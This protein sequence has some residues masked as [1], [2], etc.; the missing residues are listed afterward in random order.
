VTRNQKYDA[1]TRKIIRQTL[2]T[3]SCCVDIGCHKGEILDLMLQSSSKGLKYGFEPIP[4]LFNSLREKYK[5]DPT[6][7]INPTALYNTTGK[8][9]FQ[10][11]INAPAYSGIKK[12]KYDGKNVEIEQITVN[13]GLMDDIIPADI[14][15]DLMKIDVEGAEFQVMKGALAILKRCKPVVIFEFGLGAADF[16]GSTPELLY[17]FITNDCGMRIS[18]LKGYLCNQPSLTKE[19]L[20][21]LFELGKE[22]YFVAHP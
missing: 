22:Y 1:Y 9:T 17:Q 16:Y 3:D 4:E 11:V 19:K 21:I 5:S 7:V 13:T 2:K 10:Y 14:C 20:S 12:R 8:T 18:T 6:V 15:I